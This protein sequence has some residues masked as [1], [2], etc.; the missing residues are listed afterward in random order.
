M[1]KAIANVSDLQQVTLITKGRT[2]KVRCVH[3][4]LKGK[5][6]STFV[7]EHRLMS[8]NVLVFSFEMSFG[9]HVLVFCKNGC[10]RMYSWY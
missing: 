7:A 9:W 2:W 1:F 3:G 5:G 10:E 6:W 8:G 4:Y